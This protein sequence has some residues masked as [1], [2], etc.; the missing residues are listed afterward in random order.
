MSLD[1]F[2]QGFL[3]GEPSERGG[4]QMREV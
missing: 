1:V 2:F 4:V 3:A